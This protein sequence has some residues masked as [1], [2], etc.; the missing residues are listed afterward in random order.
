MILASNLRDGMDLYDLGKSVPRQ[1][2]RQPPNSES[3]VVMT[4]CFLNNGRSVMCGSPTGAVVISQRETGVY[5]QML[6]HDG[7]FVQLE[8]RDNS[9][10]FPGHAVQAVCVRDPYLWTSST[11][12]CRIQAHQA[13]D[14]SYVATATAGTAEDT[15]I[16]IWRA[17]I[18]D[19]ILL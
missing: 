15:C 12:I 14:F 4:V 6:E 5:Q 11:H 10:P 3:N 13:E 7:Q 17:P 1:S 8:M 9:D 16:R 2:Y 18:G 19:C